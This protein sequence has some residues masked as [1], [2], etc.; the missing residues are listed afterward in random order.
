MI[1]DINKVTNTYACA[2]C[3]QQFTQACSLQRHAVRCTKG[4]TAVSCPGEVVKRLQSAYEK[5]FYPKTN[6]SKGSIDWIEY[7]A[8]KET[9]IY[10]TPAVAA[11]TNAGWQEH[12]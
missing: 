2:H 5:V 8:E 11:E 1:M 4:K 6:D 3:N 12:L 9:F 7:E 10:T